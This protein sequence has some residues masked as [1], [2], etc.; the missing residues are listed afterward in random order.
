VFAANRARRS[1]SGLLQEGGLGQGQFLPRK[2]ALRPT[3]VS[4]TGY[5]QRAYVRPKAMTCTG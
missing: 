1:V 4:E 3:E 2:C 5:D